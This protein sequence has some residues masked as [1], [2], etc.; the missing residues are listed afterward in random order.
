MT[1][2]IVLGGILAALYLLGRIRIG[3]AVAYSNAGLFLTIKAGP[4]RIQVLP[5][6]AD[7]KEKKPSQK[8][9]EKTAESEGEQKKTKRNVKDTISMALR[10]LPLIGEAAGRFKRKIR[11]DRLKLSVIWGGEDPAVAAQGYGAGNAAMGILWPI[12]EHN[13]KVIE[14]DLRVDVD[15]ERGKPEFI[16]DAQATLTIGQCFSLAL[17][18]GIKALKIYL[19]IRR[20]QTEKN[21][22]E[23]AVQA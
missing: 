15:F 3:A 12:V 4:S 8:T 20:E 1:F 22:N 11:I 13:F 17:I 2:W 14:Y 7:K 19:G 9:K 18:L 23:K 5:A 21:E 10:F 6:K 16:A